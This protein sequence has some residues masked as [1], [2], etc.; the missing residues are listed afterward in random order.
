M[1]LLENVEFDYSSIEA[2]ITDKHVGYIGI[3][4]LKIF[5]ATSCLIN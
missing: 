2:K 1:L 4:L 3:L 5:K